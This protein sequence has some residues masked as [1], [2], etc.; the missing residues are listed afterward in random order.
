M[1]TIKAFTQRANFEDSRTD[2]RSC[3]LGA[4]LVGEMFPISL[5]SLEN[6]IPLASFSSFALQVFEYNLTTKNSASSNSSS[7]ILSGVAIAD[8]FL[9]NE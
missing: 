6:K 4:P 5:L 7:L 2:L 1:P 8:N 3:C 9:N